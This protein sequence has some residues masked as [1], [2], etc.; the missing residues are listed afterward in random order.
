MNMEAFSKRT[1]QVFILTVVLIALFSFLPTGISSLFRCST[2]DPYSGA[3]IA[4]NTLCSS[5]FQFRVMQIASS[6]FF[7]VVGYIFFLIAIVC[8][9][10][11]TRK[12]TNLVTS[13]GVVFLSLALALLFQYSRSNAVIIA[14]GETPSPLRNAHVEWIFFDSEAKSRP[15][16]KINSSDN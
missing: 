5:Y 15:V 6:S 9:F 2:T 4:A 3:E 12:P 13:T 7:A 16:R 1:A 10:L 8:F 11:T 14:I